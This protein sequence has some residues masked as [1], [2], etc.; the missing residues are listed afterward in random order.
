MV[1]LPPI[2][3]ALVHR[4]FRLFAVGQCV[5]LIGTWMQQVAITWLV[6]RLTESAFLLGV[7]GFAGQIPTL[8]VAPVAGVLS[9][10]LPRH[11]TLLIT[12]FASMI[13][14]MVLAALTWFGWVQVWHLL[15]L[16]IVLGVINAFDMP[17]RQAFLQ[18][19]V[20]HRAHLPNAIALNSSMVNGARLV[21]P[22]LAGL[23]I[24]W[25]GEISCFLL[26]AVSYLAVLV[27]LF[28]IRDLPQPD[29]GPR[30]PVWHGLVEGLT[31]AGGFAPIR[32]LLFMVALVSMSAMPLSTLMPVY[33]RE[34][35]H[36][37]PGLLG[38]L[39]AASG[40]GAL[41]S[42]LYLAGRATVLGLGKQLAVATALFG[43]SVTG[44]AWS[45]NVYLSLAFLAVSGFS[46]M[47]QLAASNTLLQTIVED[48]KRG[49]IMSLYVMAFMGTAPLGSLLSGVLADTWSAPVAL[50]T[51]GVACV[52]GAW[53]FASHLP[54]MREEVR[55]I[56]RRQGILPM[57]DAVG[58]LPAR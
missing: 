56:Y 1:T 24:A 41:I 2:A 51:G 21:G 12:Q 13:Q 35:L 44:F 22:S 40:C 6:Y 16:S 28:A 39:M 33:A 5:S 27:A 54:R 47:L 50:T 7:V 20:P 25:G 53:L 14:A 52:V 34:I 4:N 49:R 30:Q 32:V 48:D 17:T 11:R 42:A 38:V 45:G 19:L 26:N 46:M 43:I 18:E 37:G 9:D 8:F 57:D 58:H 36:G 10:R 23:M 29:P 15:V 31:Y 55:P 3:K